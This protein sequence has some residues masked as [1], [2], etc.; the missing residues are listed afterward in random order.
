VVINDGQDTFRV[1]EIRAESGP[2]FVFHHG[3]G[4]AALSFGLVTMEM[5]QATPDKFSVLAYDCRG[6]GHTQT[7]QDTNLSLQQLSDDL[8][9]VV[10]ACR[11]DE[12]QDVILVGHR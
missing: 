2:L 6:H 5:R 10:A 1:Y 8:A 11:R 12:K 7:A 9:N 4:Q 3:A